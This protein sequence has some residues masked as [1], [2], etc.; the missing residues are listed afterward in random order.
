M[1]NKQPK[2]TWQ[3]NHTPKQKQPASEP[4]DFKPTTSFQILKDKE[5][6][7]EPPPEKGSESNPINIIK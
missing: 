3:E 7:K 4:K 5:I 2:V 6:G 1:E